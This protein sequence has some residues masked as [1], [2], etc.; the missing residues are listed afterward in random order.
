MNSRLCRITMSYKRSL[1]EYTGM[2][3]RVYSGRFL[4]EAVEGN[5]EER[6]RKSGKDRENSGDK[7]NSKLTL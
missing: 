3:S 1:S 5:E 7:S 2:D 4:Y 6:G